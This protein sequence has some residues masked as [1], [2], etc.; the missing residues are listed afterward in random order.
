M[1]GST[2][3]PVNT[4]M[5]LRIA[6]IGQD[7]P[8]ALTIVR[9]VIHRKAQ[10]NLLVAVKDGKLQI[11]DRGPLPVL[12][13]EKGTPITVIPMSGVGSFADA[14]DHTRIAFERHEAGNATRLVLNRG[15]RSLVNGSTDRRRK[16]DAKICSRSDSAVRFG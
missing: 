10:T 5:R 2:T 7:E 11:E 3:G 16:G 4:K 14:G 15:G 6:R 13:F 9:A 1:V 8:I 12:D